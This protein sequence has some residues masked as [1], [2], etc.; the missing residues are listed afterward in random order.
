MKW[1]RW[2]RWTTWSRWSKWT[3]WSRKRLNSFW[4]KYFILK[5]WSTSFIHQSEVVH[6]SSSWINDTS[7]ADGFRRKFFVKK[8]S[9]NIIQAKVFSGEWT[10]A[11]LCMHLLF[12]KSM[13]VFGRNLILHIPLSCPSKTLIF[14]SLSFSLCLVTPNLLIHSH[15]F[16]SIP[17]WINIRC[18]SHI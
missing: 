10:G 1:T 14:I 16:P 7:L 9:G 13:G 4:M 5:M 18:D 3:R 15:S 6:W 17:I 11:L 2:S 12:P 8:L